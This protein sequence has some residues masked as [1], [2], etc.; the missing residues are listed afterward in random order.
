[1]NINSA[2]QPPEL[3]YCLKNVS[4]Q[5]L[6]VA[7]NFK[8]QDYYAMVSEVIPEIPFSEP[9]KIQSPAAPDFK[10]LICMGNESRQ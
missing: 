3:L 8:T 6:V 5:C 4:V 9:G 1:V 10:T 7:E 2:Y